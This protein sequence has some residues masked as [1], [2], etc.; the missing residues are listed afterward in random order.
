MNPNRILSVV[1]V[2]LLAAAAGPARAQT[3]TRASL[4]VTGTQGNDISHSARISGDGRFV[5]FET[6]ATNLVPSD[7][8][9]N[10]DVLVRDLLLGTTTVISVNTAGSQGIPGTGSHL[11]DISE[12][13]RF[14]VFHSYAPNFGT[15]GDGTGVSDIFIRDRD[16]D[17]N[18]VFDEAGS[19]TTQISIDKF[20]TQPNAGSTNA[21][22]SDDGKIVAFGSS[23]T[24][25]VPAGGASPA[26][27][28]RDLAAGTNELISV[29]MF[30]LPATAFVQDISSD[31]RYVLFWSNDPDLVVGDTNGISDVFV[32][33]RATATTTRISDG[34]AGAEPDGWSAGS[35]IS[36]NGR[37]VTFYSRAKNLV[38]GGSLE[39]ANAFVRDRDPDAN[40]VC[41]EANAFTELVSIN[42]YEVEGTG[43]IEGTYPPSISDDGRYVAFT[44]GDSSGTCCDLVL[45]DVNGA[46][47][48]FIRDRLKGVTT[49]HSVNDDG[50]VFGFKSWGPD[51]D[52]SGE[53]LAFS[54]WSPLDPA[55]TNTHEDIYVRDQ[56]VWRDLAWNMTGSSAPPK[57]VP[58][59]TGH[60]TLEA[61]SAGSLR[62]VQAKKGATSFLV[63]G[64]TQLSVPFLGGILVPSANIVVIAIPVSS[65][66]T[67]LGGWEAP[68]TW[69]AG[70]PSAQVWVA[71]PAGP[72]GYVSSNGLRGVAP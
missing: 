63:A 52:A 14:I 13:G 56:S 71:D 20:G 55:D 54:T 41:D 18:G 59:L 70:V 72:F 2:T 33:D 8:N 57:S 21:Q 19:T 9:A 7:S 62:L 1:L 49:R 40:G 58:V 50:A 3:S 61:S 29:D 12:D 38:A 48:V 51:F 6:V 26:V 43:L 15:M 53:V 64:T 60:G 4:G 35:R 68:V 39:F 23:A 37:F 17:G 36:A 34:Y 42:S 25:L 5:A 16:V 45:E 65:P 67:P 47:D 46:F 11:P 10:H 66:A 30:G 27:F 31:G 28:V 22:I 44:G 69:P 24:D 32:R